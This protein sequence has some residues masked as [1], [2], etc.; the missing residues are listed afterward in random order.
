MG[1]YDP[2]HVYNNPA[3]FA[4]LCRHD[5]SIHASYGLLRDIVERHEAVIQK[6]WTKKSK[7]QKLKVLLDSWPCMPIMH[8]PDFDAFRKESS[9][10]PTAGTKYRQ[11]YLWSK[12]SLEDLSKPKHL[13]WLINS[14]SRHHPSVFAA[15]DCEST[16]LG[17]VCQATSPIFLNGHVMTL[18]SA[19][20]TESYG[21]LLEWDDHPDAFDWCLLSRKQ[22]T[23]GEGLLVLEIQERL[24]HFLVDCCYKILH[25]IPP[26]RLTCDVFPTQPEPHLTT[27][28]DATG[29]ASL[30]VMAEEAPYRVPSRIDFARIESLLEARM[31]AAKDH[32][33]ALREDPAYLGEV[34][35]QVKEHRLEM[36]KDLNGNIHPALEP[37]R[38]GVFWAR[39]SNFVVCQAYT[40]LLIFAEL[41]EQAMH[42]RSLHANHAA[43]ISPSSDLPEELLTAILRFRHFLQ[44]V[45]R[46]PLYHVRTG[47]MGS[48][49]MRKYFVRDPPPNP[50]TSLITSRPKPG[51]GTDLFMLDMTLVLAEIERLVQ[52]EKQAADLVSAGVAHNIAD[53]A[54]IAQCL[55]QLKMY[56]PWARGYDEACV[57][58]YK[59]VFE[60]E[61]DQWSRTVKL[62]L[63]RIKDEDYLR[64]AKLVD[65]SDKRFY[66]PA[67]KRRTKENVEAL[68]RAEQNADNFW[69]AAD[70]VVYS[71]C[72]D[73]AGTAL[74]AALSEQRSLKRT[75]EWVDDG[76]NAGKKGRAA[77]LG[78][79]EVLYKPSSTM[80]FDLSSTAEPGPPRAKTKTKTKTKVK[81]KGTL[82]EESTATPDDDAPPC[83]DEPQ[84]PPVPVDARS[85]K[86]F[87]TLLFN[88]GVTLSPGEISWTDFV[89]AMTSTRLFAAEKLY[90]SVWQFQRLDEESQSRIQFHQPHPR[91]KIQFTWARRYGRRLTRNFGW[92]G[93]MFVLRGSDTPTT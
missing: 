88:P 5:S 1:G 41:H 54:I 71:R 7:Q 89:H 23:R 79:G 28:F 6:R 37:S 92:V 44:E 86:V 66:Y 11:N 12:V 48:P 64:S 63:L 21:E 90:G 13:L 19:T 67:H 32:I 27:E 49:P 3:R 72:G 39:I 77:T 58:N 38:S 70:K 50:T 20:D 16:R 68:R 74:H 33:W 40:E 57:N 80:Y 69:A 9:E 83:D 87:R 61:S 35:T 46:H 42:L 91:G 36:L 2:D 34:V 43:Q 45:A 59:G 53:L 81:T 65:P 25:D 84:Q 51:N 10:Q 31:S 62:L 75:P 15:S 47:F 8:R 52:T 24:L 78:D 18:N 56:Q 73:L 22:F 26:D 76:L 85:L 4:E 29:F 17:N 82:R 55:L 30:S 60:K 14:R 93:S